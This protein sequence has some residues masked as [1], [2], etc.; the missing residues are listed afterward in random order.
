MT[1]ACSIPSWPPPTSCAARLLCRGGTTRRSARSSTVGFRRG[2]WPAR[3]P[4]NDH[5]DVQLEVSVQAVS[6]AGI[7]PCYSMNGVRKEQLLPANLV[8]GDHALPARRHEPVGKAL[9]QLQLHVRILGRVHDDHA[10]GVEEAGVALHQHHQIGTVLERQPGATIGQDIGVQRRC[11]V[12]RRPHA[13]ST[14]LVAGGF[15][16]GQV[17][18]GDFPIT[19][20]GLIG[21]ALVAARHKGLSGGLELE[22]SRGHILAAHVG[23]VRLRTDQ[24]KVVVHHGLALQAETLGH[25]LLFGDRVVHEHHIGVA[26]TCHVECLTG[27]H[28]HHAHLYAGV[29]GERRQQMPEQAGL[30]GRGGRSHH[31]ERC[32]SAGRKTWHQQC[33]GQ[34]QMG[35]DSLQVQG[36]SPLRK[37]A[38]SCGSAVLKNSC[39]GRSTSTRPASI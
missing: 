13:T 39:G 23:R 25:E 29:L 14:S 20:L 27:A 33:G 15:V 16:G 10:I 4:A 35:E 6:C 17:D 5:A 3:Q 38:A 18:A 12:Q 2:V 28:C 30:L 8:I 24:H 9:P 36:S 34:Q 32:V 31:D 11:H 21:A 22:Q 37:S 1:P 7:R 26:A 19:Q